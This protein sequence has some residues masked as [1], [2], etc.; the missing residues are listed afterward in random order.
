MVA[1]LIISAAKFAYS[2]GNGLVDCFHC[3]PQA[4]SMAS[5]SI[6]LVLT[7][8]DFNGDGIQDVVLRPANDT[9]KQANVTGYRVCRIGPSARSPV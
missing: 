8:N 3:R 6:I 9:R 4:W 1:R 5:T 7:V 2:R